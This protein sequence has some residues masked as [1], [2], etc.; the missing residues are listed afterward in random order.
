M[1]TTIS[2]NGFNLTMI[3][4]VTID[5]PKSDGVSWWRNLRPLSELQR[6]YPDVQVD[7]IGEDMKLPMLLKADVIIMFR[8]VRPKTLQFLENCKKEMFNT[9]IILDIDDNLWRIPPGH[10]C[11]IEYAEYGD[12]LRRIYALADGIWC[13]TDAIMPF[14]DGYDG[15]GI[16][17]PN[18]VLPRDLPDAPAPYK[19]L[20]CWRGSIANFMDINSD[21]AFEQFKENQERFNWWV[22]FGYWPARIRGRN[23]G[24]KGS[25]PVTDYIGSLKTMGINIMWKPLEDNEFNAAK[26]NIAWIEATMSGGICV[27]NFAG[28]SGWEMA[29]DKFT[30]N[31]D[32]IASQWEASRDWILKY[33]NLHMVNE[34]RYQHILKVLGI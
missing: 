24:G 8:P 31:P 27:T 30:D 32:F 11:E 1:T 34:L 21:E 26:S 5:D 20:V 22:M 18:A 10:P 23:V 14:V 25:V 15:R 7:F 4:I 19:G 9:K 6:R 16:V 3:R 28:R 13:S 33:Y 2:L 12:T 29:V 17:I